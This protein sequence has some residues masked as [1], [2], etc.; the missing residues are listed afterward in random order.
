MTGRIVIPTDMSAVEGNSWFIYT[1]LDIRDR[2]TS[3]SSRDSGTERRSRKSR[4][5]EIDRKIEEAR[6]REEA[7]KR[8]QEQKER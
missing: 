8:L 6:K 1:S 2:S 3:E 5:K 4:M 7:E